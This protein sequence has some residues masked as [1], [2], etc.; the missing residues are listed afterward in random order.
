MGEEVLARHVPALHERHPA[1]VLDL[2]TDDRQLSLT[3]R[4]AD[5]AV[6]FGRP[7]QADLVVRRVGTV[8]YAIYASR[9]YV[10][11]HGVTASNLGEH[12]VVTYSDDLPL[13]AQVAWLRDHG[14]RVASHSNNTNIVVDMVLADM[15]IAALG[16][17]VGDRR[18]DLVRIVDPAEL[19][20]RELLM[21]VHAELQKVPRVRAVADWIVDI[22]SQDADLISGQRPQPR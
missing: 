7:D 12:P 16:C 10:A 8:A 19:A 20:T 3:R 21:V 6:R 1:L 18:P 5:L 4:E 13:L 14:G 9:T 2:N 22:T 11:R 15:G 17:Y